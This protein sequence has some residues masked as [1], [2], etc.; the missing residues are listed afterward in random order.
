MKSKYQKQ[1][2]ANER[3]RGSI[4]MYQRSIDESTK[5]KDPEL[6]QN[7]VNNLTKKIDTLERD[8]KLTEDR[9]NNARGRFD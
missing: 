2:E 9:M 8:I 3:R 4:K 7:K 6:R 5:I 1:V